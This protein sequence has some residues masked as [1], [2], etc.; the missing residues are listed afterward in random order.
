[1]APGEHIAQFYEDDSVLIDALTGFV[2]GGLNAGEST[3]II[4]TLKHLQL[5][6]RRLVDADV[7][8]VGAILEDRYIALDA[9]A[10]LAS[11]MVQGWPDDERFNSLVNQLLGR[12]T[13]KNRRVRVFG[14]MVALLWG[15]GHAAA[16]VRIE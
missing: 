10:A 6:E 1:M 5:L 11:F 3:I 7:D 4:A 8:L 2:S 12:A 15:S 9:E 16:T 13:V 14:E